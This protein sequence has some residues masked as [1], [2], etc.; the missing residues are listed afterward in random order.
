MDATRGPIL[1][2]CDGTPDGGWEPFYQC[3]SLAAAFQRRRRG[4]HFLSYLDPAS[5]AIAVNRGNNDWIPANQTLGSAGDLG[6]TIAQVRRLNA[7]A[8]ILAGDGYDED[9]LADLR[10]TG[11]LVVVFDSTAGMRFDADVVVNPFSAPGR[12]A[13]RP[14]PGTQ[15]LLGHKYALCRGV[16][17]RQ[18]TIRATEPV[19][20]FRALVA[21]G[22]D[23]PAGEAFTRTQQLLEMG[24]VAKVSVACRSHHPRYADLKDLA[25]ADDRVEVVTEAKELM[26]R[27]VRSHFALT[28]GDGWSGE[29]CVVGLPQLVMSQT[30][31]H[32]MNAKRMDEDGVA[33]FLGDAA[34]VSFEQL[35]E[36]V[37]LLLDDAMERKTMTRC[38]RNQY[39]GRGPDRVVNGMEILLHAP[40]RKRAAQPLPALRIAA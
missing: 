27:L 24:K 35:K 21:M 38:A 9:Y 11:T 12:K 40:A 36:A 10:A 33:T 4:T 16:F 8:V 22:D 39:D 14:G 25:E 20:P 28:C 17:R 7:A 15:L 26:T 37:D 34:D 31:R 19:G 5:L 1:F 30:K 29:L 18:R 3:L 2:R 6:A 32:G 23:D 13:Y